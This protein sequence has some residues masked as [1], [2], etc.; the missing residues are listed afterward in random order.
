MEWWPSDIVLGYIFLKCESICVLLLVKKGKTFLLFFLIYFRFVTMKKNK[1]I[2]NGMAVKQWQSDSLIQLVILLNGNNKIYHDAFCFYLFTYRLVFLCDV[3]RLSDASMSYLFMLGNWRERW[4][5]RFRKRNHWS[6]CQCLCLCLGFPLSPFH[7]THNSKPLH[8]RHYTLSLARSLAHLLFPFTLPVSPSPTLKVQFKSAQLSLHPAVSLY[9]CQTFTLL[10]V[11]VLQSGFWRGPSGR[12]GRGK[13]IRWG[14]DGRSFWAAQKERLWYWFQDFP[15]EPRRL[16]KLYLE[17]V[18]FKCTCCAITQTAFERRRCVLVCEL[19][20]SFFSCQ[21]M[22]SWMWPNSISTSGFTCHQSALFSEAR[23]Q[24]TTQSRVC[25]SFQ[26]NTL[27]LTLL[28]QQG[29]WPMKYD[30]NPAVFN[31]F[32]PILALQRYHHIRHTKPLTWLLPLN[33][34]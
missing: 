17:E 11:F 32:Y 8:S 4:R 6:V 33:M 13:P 24:M 26:P 1:Q 30:I 16:C 12:R 20:L 2:S 22:L 14:A 21:C 31:L 18:C 10:P 7:H 23:F 27:T 19:F 28:L 9:T 15:L 5:V 34:M 29:L 3:W 25:I